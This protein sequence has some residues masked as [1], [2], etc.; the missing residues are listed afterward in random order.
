MNAIEKVLA[1]AVVVFAILSAGL[2]ITLKIE[3]GR[4][5]LAQTQLAEATRARE[6]AE[7]ERDAQVAALKVLKAQLA[8][9]QE[10]EAKAKGKLNDALNANRE[11]SNAAV[12][13]SVYDALFGAD[14]TSGGAAR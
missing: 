13:D 9:L 7:K 6:Q 5:V 14:A 8:K 11:W 2:G 4:T 12:P 3:H 10:D 1:G